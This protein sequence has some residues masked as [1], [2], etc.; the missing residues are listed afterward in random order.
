MLKLAAGPYVPDQAAITGGPPS[1]RVSPT[2]VAV[3]DLDAGHSFRTGIA[4]DCMPEAVASRATAASRTHG[5]TCGRLA[6]APRGRGAMSCLLGEALK[7][8]LVHFPSVGFRGVDVA[9][10]VRSQQV[11]AQKLA[12]IRPG[13]A[14]RSL[15]ED[16]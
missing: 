15:R 7:R 16:I 11:Q 12:R 4:P 13:V 9:L 1:A 8:P 14:E 2:A 3:L 6:N 10:G 5:V